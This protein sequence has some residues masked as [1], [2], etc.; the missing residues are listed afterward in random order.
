MKVKNIIPSLK[1]FN[2]SGESIV[3]AYLADC[4]FSIVGYDGVPGAVRELLKET[5]K[6][7]CAVLP[8]YEGNY[9][10]YIKI[11]PTDKRIFDKGDEAYAITVTD[12][13][14]ELASTSDKGAYYAAVTLAELITV[15]GCEV[16]LPISEIVDYPTFSTRGMYLESRFNDFM[17]LDE[18]KSAVDDFSAL[19]LNKMIVGIYGC[20]AMQYDRQLSQYMYLKLDRFPEMKVSKAKK[21]YSVKQDKWVVEEPEY[22]TMY[23]EDYFD[24]LIKYGKSKNVEV[25][26]LFNS[27]GHNSLLPEVYPEISAKD[28]NGS[29]TG[30]G[31]CTSSEKTY[32]VVLGIYDEII[33]KYLAPNGITSFAIGMDEVW[34]CKGIDKADIYKEFSPH[35]KCKGCRDA[36]PSE[37]MIQY[38]IRLLKHLKS[39]G[40]KSVYVYHDMFFYEYD[41]LNEKLAQRFKDEGVYDITVIDWWSYANLESTVFRG[42]ANDVNGLFRST[43]KPMAGYE[44]WRY[45]TDYT[46]NIKYLGKLAEEH[47]F[48]GMIA[49]TTYEPMLDYNYRYFAESVWNGACDESL[50]EY[51]N[52][53][54]MNF[55]G[56]R[57]QK[58]RDAYEEYIETVLPSPDKSRPGLPWLSQYTY[59][60]IENGLDYPRD[61]L[62][63]LCGKITDER[64]KY[65]GYLNECVDC[66]ERALEFFDGVG[67]RPSAVNENIAL[68]IRN[69]KVLAN[70]IKVLYQL[71][72]ASKAGLYTCEL[73]LHLIDELINERRKLMLEVENVRLAGPRVTTLRIM[74]ISLEY[75][76]EIRAKIKKQMDNG[77]AFSLDMK[78]LVDRSAGIFE[79][80]R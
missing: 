30:Y 19:K 49:Y 67:A 7:K 3:I 42:R 36:E 73:A 27:L 65:T 47:N 38:V 48:E 24:A 32:E 5:F 15:E 23:T 59:A 4:R 51:K 31:M 44:N 53:Y 43:A 29:D 25:V 78:N 50:D 79:F 45:Y 11:D 34:P 61:H 2:E 63:E 17:T 8:P 46:R 68:N 58:A 52:K 62:A 66:A 16:R 35:C 80:L 41:N 37:H 71:H 28:E 76:T 39:R 12:K 74:T 57:W 26:P 72:E 56:D 21:Y 20:W 40:M 14:T 75:L 13:Y 55:Y 18:W 54:F 6:D 60:S 22:P 70:E 69:H 33:D 1:N 77:E 64:D 10:I 9:K